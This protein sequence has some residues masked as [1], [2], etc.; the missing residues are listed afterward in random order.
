[1]FNLGKG[2]AL[3]GT[4]LSSKAAGMEVMLGSYM[5][6]QATGQLFWLKAVPFG[7]HLIIKK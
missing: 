5:H 1:M 3:N 4:A 6:G 7:T 2:D